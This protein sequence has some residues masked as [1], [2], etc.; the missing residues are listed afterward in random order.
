MMV[1]NISATVIKKANAL[2]TKCIKSWLGLT[3]ST[4]AAVLHHPNIINIPSLASLK[5]K[6]KLTYLASVVVSQDPLIE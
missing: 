6:A 2:A 3:R 5:I 4:S 1:N